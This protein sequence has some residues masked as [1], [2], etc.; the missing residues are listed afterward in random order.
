MD[1][2]LKRTFES[3]TLPDTLHSGKNGS[4]MDLLDGTEIPIKKDDGSKWSRT[5]EGL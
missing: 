3:T 5:V 1:E 4:S 2:V